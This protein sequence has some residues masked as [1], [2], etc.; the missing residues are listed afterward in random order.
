MKPEVAEF[1]LINLRKCMTHLTLEESTPLSAITD[2]HT[3]VR[4][5][6]VKKDIASKASYVLKLDIP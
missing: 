3:C 1:N 6:Q 2:S 5:H 4:N